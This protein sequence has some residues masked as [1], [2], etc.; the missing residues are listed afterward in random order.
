MIPNFEKYHFLIRFERSN[1]PVESKENI[2]PNDQLQFRNNKIE[3]FEKYREKS[4]SRSKSPLIYNNA[5]YGIDMRIKT[6][7]NG[8]PYSAGLNYERGVRRHFTTNHLP[9][10]GNNMYGF[11]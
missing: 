11:N 3:T 4:A 8:I 1:F 7:G 2:L 6:T 5:N 10:I 9:N